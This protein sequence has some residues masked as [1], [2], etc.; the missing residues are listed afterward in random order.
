MLWVVALLLGLMALLSVPVDLVFRVRRETSFRASLSVRWMFGLVG[1]PVRRQPKKKPAKPKPEKPKKSGRGR[2]IALR[3]LGALRTADF[4]RRVL[5]FLKQF[6]AAV[7]LRNLALRLRVGF[8][9]PADTGFFWA[10]FWPL[11]P[12]LQ[13]GPSAR[14]DVGP[15]FAGE[16]LEVDGRGEIRIIPAQMIWIAATFALSPVTLRTAAAQRARS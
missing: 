5:Q 8:D 1:F 11:I 9:D 14:L 7:H 4:R 12:L 10:M 2:R 16:S 3:V 13:T 6:T 15:E